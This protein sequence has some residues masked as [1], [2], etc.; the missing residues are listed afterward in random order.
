MSSNEAQLLS[1]L[2]FFLKRLSRSNTSIAQ[3]VQK[4]SPTLRKA[5]D[6]SQPKRSTRPSILQGRRKNNKTSTNKFQVTPEN[7][8]EK[9]VFP[10]S[11]L[12]GLHK[13]TWLAAWSC[14]AVKPCRSPQ[15]WTNNTHA[16]QAMSNECFNSWLSSQKIL[17]KRRARSETTRG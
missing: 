8:R 7:N 14:S 9:P 10:G 12:Q 4:N 5:K 6:G 3:C 13:L 1:K 15:Q 11:Q 17:G 16:E 2:V